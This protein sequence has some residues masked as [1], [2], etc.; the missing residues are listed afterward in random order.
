MLI[1]CSKIEGANYSVKYNVMPYVGGLVYGEAGSTVGLVE[2]E[3][4]G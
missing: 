2:F 1:L 3:R 4:T